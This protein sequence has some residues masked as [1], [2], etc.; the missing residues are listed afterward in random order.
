MRFHLILLKNWWVV[1]FILMAGAIYIQAIHKK[2]QLVATLQERVDTL[3]T[4]KMDA[5]EKKEEL[6][7]RIN[8]QN[9][10]DFVELILKEKLGVTA[11]GELKVV[12]Q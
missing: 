8:S 1:A 4:A 12:F 7:L 3:A 9:D 10:P 11:E 6:L 5:M 2:N